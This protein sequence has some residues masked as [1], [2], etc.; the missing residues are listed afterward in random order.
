MNSNQETNKYKK[1]ILKDLEKFYSKLSELG[2]NLEELKPIMESESN[3]QIILSGAGSGKTTALIL[4]IIHEFVCGNLHIEENING[5]MVLVQKN[6]LVS[7]FLKTGAEEL[8]ESLKEWCFKLGITNIDFGKINFRTIHSEVYGAL[9]SM[10]INLNITLNTKPI[11]K[12][13]M[14]MLDIKSL[15]NTSNKITDSEVMDMSSLISYARNRLDE[16]KYSHSLMKNFN[17]RKGDLD[18]VLNLFNDLKDN[19]NLMDFED[20]QELL[21]KF[22]KKD[23]ETI[24]FVQNR[25]DYIFVD[26]FQ[27]TSQLQYSILQYYFL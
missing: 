4:K 11:I 20:M 8:E 12:R 5:E 7:T 1:S 27:D 9:S 13:T 15:G 21:L 3:I 10:G 19:S 16:K 2:Y 14:D 18:R 24:E 17:L 25:Y 23:R 6:I 22:L 26:E